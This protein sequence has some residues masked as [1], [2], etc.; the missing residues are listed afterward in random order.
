[1]AVFTEAQLK[2]DCRTTLKMIIQVK[3]RVAFTLCAEGEGFKSI[4][5]WARAVLRERVVTSPAIAGLGLD[6]IEGLQIALDAMGAGAQANAVGLPGRHETVSFEA[7]PPGPRD[8]LPDAIASATD[9][10]RANWEDGEHEKRAGK[11][12][13]PVEFHPVRCHATV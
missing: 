8:P 5:S 3:D 2:Q 12:P 13:K 4:T 10:I 11:V 6:T 1:M 7:A 9:R